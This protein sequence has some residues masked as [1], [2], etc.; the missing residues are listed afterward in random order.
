MHASLIG[1]ERI[2]L[3]HVADDPA[4]LLGFCVDVS[5]K[6]A[7]SPGCGWMKAKQRVNE[8][9]LARAVRTKQADAVAAQFALQIIQD[10]PLAEFNPQL[11]EFNN[12]SGIH[13]TRHLS[14]TQGAN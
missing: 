1:N 4:N 11:V 14:R 7:R 10:A 12:R 9:R 13:I 6:D 2:A 8:R 5:A 3:G